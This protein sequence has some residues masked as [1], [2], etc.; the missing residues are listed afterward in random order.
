MPGTFSLPLTSTEIASWWSQHT[1]RHVRHARAWMHVGIASVPGI[2]GA[3]T[4]RNFT[5]LARGPWKTLRILLMR[6]LLIQSPH[7]HYWNI[8]FFNYRNTT[9]LLNT[10]FISD[11]STNLVWSNVFTRHFHTVINISIL[12]ISKDEALAI[13]F[14]S[15]AKQ[16]LSH[17]DNLTIIMWYGLSWKKILGCT[18][19]ISFFPPLL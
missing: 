4:T 13:P 8:L 2:P 12:K 11:T 18:F 10:L 19:H 5:Y 15:T 3:C 16:L 1:S 7:F 17:W 6:G 9:F 14:P